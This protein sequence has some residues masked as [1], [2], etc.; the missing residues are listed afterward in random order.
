[1]RCVR[2]CRFYVG[3]AWEMSFALPSLCHW[4][5]T[6]LIDESSADMVYWAYLILAAFSSFLGSMLVA[7]KAIDDALHAVI[8]LLVLI[9]VA[10][11]L[12]FVFLPESVTPSASLNSLLAAGD[13]HNNLSR[14]SYLYWIRPFE[15][16]YASF[17]LL[18][19][20]ANLTYVIL[21][22]AVFELIQQRDSELELQYLQEVAEFS[23]V[24]QSTYLMV[25]F[26]VATCV[27]SIIFPFWSLFS[28][29]T[30]KDAFGFGFVMVAVKL[31]GM[32]FVT[33][34]KLAY[35]LEM[36]GAMDALITVMIDRV[37]DHHCTAST[38]PSVHQ[39]VLGIRSLAQG[40]SPLFHAS[41]FALFRL[42]GLYFPGAPFVSL[43]AL[44][45]VGL[46]LLLNIRVEQ[47]GFVTPVSI[48]LRIVTLT[49]HSDDEDLE[50]CINLPVSGRGYVSEEDS[51][52]S[53][54]TTATSADEDEPSMLPAEDRF[55]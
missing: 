2:V 4:Y 8:I 21:V 39:A 25:R 27:Y 52:N 28:N 20:K 19:R 13:V 29:R 24:E 48:F 1:M 33:S 9:S 46:L 34:K 40:L 44:A 55:D 49:F 11:L 32:I 45:L 54:S 36:F 31:F 22:Y 38:S 6:D 18:P 50:N 26:L 14:A 35:F 7:S 51:N 5:F 37:L 16:M 17:R 12:S 10:L 42:G 47:Y 23:T 30:Y 53:S 43:F 15:D 3:K 41:V